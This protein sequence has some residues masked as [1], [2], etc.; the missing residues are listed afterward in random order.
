MSMEQTPG[1][2]LLVAAFTQEKAGKAVLK[3]MEEAK[4]EKRIYFD[5][6][7]VVT[8]DSDGKVHYNE[9]DDMATSKGASWGAVVGS[10]IG[11][12]GGPM[13]VVGGAGAGAFIGGLASHGD[14][15]FSDDSLNQFGSALNPG[16]S[17]VITISNIDFLKTLHENVGEDELHT[18][19]GDLAEQITAQLNEGEDVIRGI[20]ITEKGPIMKPMAVDDTT[21]RVIKDA[22]VAANNS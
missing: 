9:T 5:A 10:V 16:T 19:V 3:A 11:I 7:A 18:M 15:G 14:A 8:Q 22:A 12:F 6:A 20:F 2:A 4:K 1:V 21:I 13:G 17:A